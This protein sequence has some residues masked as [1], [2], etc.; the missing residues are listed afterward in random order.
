M[1]FLNQWLT[2]VMEQFGYLGVA[3]L[4][5]LE[6]LFPPIPSE[7]VLTFGG[8]L[9]GEHKLSFIGVVLSATTGSV[10]GAILLY[11]LG[12]WIGKKRIYHFTEKYGKY[13]YI[14]ETDIDRTVHWFDKYGHWTVF[15]CRFIPVLR[16][17]ISLP[18]GMTHMSFW[19]FVTYSAAGAL[20]WNG[21]MIYLG[22]AVGN[23]WHS[24]LQYIDYYS[25]FF[26]II[27]VIAVIFLIWKWWK[28][29][30][31]DNK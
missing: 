15:F 29:K 2:H 7:I 27:L 26:I 19:T 14:K 30:K 20:I 8:F 5:F 10:A 1:K 24:V 28:R 12:A 25:K 4:I 18:A 31:S 11:G 22:K 3:L 17:L 23:H 13:V 6:N 16:C 9:A 21:I